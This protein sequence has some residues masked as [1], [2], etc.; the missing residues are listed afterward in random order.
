[1]IGGRRRPPD[2]TNSCANGYQLLHLQRICSQNLVNIVIFDPF[3]RY[4][5]LGDRRCETS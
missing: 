4:V 3:I 1:M 2:A 5:I